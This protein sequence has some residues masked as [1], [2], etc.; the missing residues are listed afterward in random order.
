MPGTPL[1]AVEMV[2]HRPTHLDCDLLPVTL[3]WKVEAAWIRH[4]GMGPAQVQPESF[5]CPEHDKQ[6]R[7]VHDELVGTVGV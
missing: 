1:Q 6:Y 3:Y 4:G 5:R 2:I 7:I